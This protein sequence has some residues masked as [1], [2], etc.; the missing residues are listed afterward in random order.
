MEG[1]CLLFLHLTLTS[2]AAVPTRL[3]FNTLQYPDESLHHSFLLGPLG[4]SEES[5]YI[6]L[7]LLVL[8]I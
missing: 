7:E 3:A 6:V 5:G 8:E 4:Y 2:L 1:S